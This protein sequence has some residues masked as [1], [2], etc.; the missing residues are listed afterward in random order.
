MNITA[1][2]TTHFA[3]LSDE[4]TQRLDHCQR[5]TEIPAQWLTCA[6]ESC[7]RAQELP[8]HTANARRHHACADL[9]DDV[10]AHAERVK[11][12]N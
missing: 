6:T 8:I 3:A 1:C 5:P 11:S 7:R 2:S 10:K 4:L 12:Q 9:I